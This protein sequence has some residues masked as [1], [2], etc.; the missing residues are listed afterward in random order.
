MRVFHTSWYHLVKKLSRF[1]AM[2][3]DDFGYVKRGRDEMGV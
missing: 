1:E 2:M 3:I